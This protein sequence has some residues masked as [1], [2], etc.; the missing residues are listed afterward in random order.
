[1]Q[2][3]LGRAAAFAPWPIPVLIQGESG[4]GKTRLARLLHALST[5]ANA[6]FEG[7]SLAEPEVGL[8]SSELFGHVAG[9]F[10]DARKG[11]NGLLMRAHHGT[12]FFDE[13]GKCP[14]RVQHK[15]LSI[16]DSQTFNP[17]SSDRSVTVDVR[18]VFAASEPLEELVA[19]GALAR[20]FR[21]RL[22]PVVLRLPPLRERREDIVPLAR[23]FAARY[24][25]RGPDPARRAPELSD[26]LC[27]SLLAYHWPDNVRQLEYLMSALVILSNGE[28]MLDTTHFGEELAG[29][30][31]HGDE[32]G[33]LEQGRQGRQDR[34]TR[35]LRQ[36]FGNKTKAATLLGWSL[37]TLKRVLR[38]I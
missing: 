17:V 4:S 10:T 19:S 2:R 29:F 36:T 7:M 27:E 1:M 5:R 8:L 14:M 32:P 25:R 33:L 30:A 22:G 28:P 24:V 13:V 3:L 12:V 20:D 35:A 37:S 18:F 6:P 31:P 15:L 11:R 23:G 34:A 9:G 16:L 38:E 21:P 26:R